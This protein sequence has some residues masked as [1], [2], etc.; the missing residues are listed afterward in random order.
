MF[1]VG[2]LKQTVLEHLALQFQDRNKR[3]KQTTRGR[4][5]KFINIPVNTS[6]N[7][8][9]TVEHF[10]TRSSFVEKCP[11]KDSQTFKLLNL[12]KTGFFP[13]WSVRPSERVIQGRARPIP[14][15]DRR[16]LR[17]LGLF[18]ERRLHG[19]Y[20]R[21]SDSHKRSLYFVASSTR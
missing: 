1:R 20:S 6:C 8:F 7:W 12:P 5:A 19:D 18:Q 17:H 4:G 13:L 2:L 11:F 15:V 14:E 9:Y 3:S 10:I 16:Y 21:T